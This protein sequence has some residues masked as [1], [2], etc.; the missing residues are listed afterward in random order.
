MSAS[1]R[2]PTSSIK[3]R[4]PVSLL[5]TADRRHVARQN[6]TAPLDRTPSACESRAC[7]GATVVASGSLLADAHVVDARVDDETQHGGTALPITPPVHTMEWL[8]FDQ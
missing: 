3:V 1:K 8:L 7:L 2:V 5:S 6:G 4:E